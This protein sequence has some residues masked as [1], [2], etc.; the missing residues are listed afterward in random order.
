MVETV[1]ERICRLKTAQLCN[2]GMDREREEVCGLE[3]HHKKTLLIES[4]RAQNTHVMMCLMNHDYF[5]LA[6]MLYDHETKWG[7]LCAFSGKLCRAIIDRF[8]LTSDIFS[9]AGTA[10][11]IKNLKSLKWIADKFYWCYPLCKGPFFHPYPLYTACLEHALQDDEDRFE[12]FFW[13]FWKI[14]DELDFKAR[15]I[16][17]TPHT[18]KEQEHNLLR[19][20]VKADKLKHLQF[21]THPFH[22]EDATMQCLAQEFPDA[23]GRMGEYL[24]KRVLHCNKRD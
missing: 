20:C 10:L 11:K 22:V 7:D 1:D 13:I 14:I 12:E 16:T 4:L 18:V 2:V 19:E 9:F 3:P 17:L 21:L 24:R 15:Y 23:Q 6:S 8:D 5:G